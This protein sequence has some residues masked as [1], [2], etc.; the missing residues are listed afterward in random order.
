MQL[1]SRSNPSIFNDSR[2][3]RGYLPNVTQKRGFAG[4]LLQRFEILR[5]KIVHAQ[6]AKHLTTRSSPSVLGVCDC[7]SWFVTFVCQLHQQRNA[8]CLTSS[9]SIRVLRAVASGASLQR[10]LRVAQ[11]NVS[12]RG[13]MCNR[14]SCTSWLAW[15]MRL[16]CPA[17][18]RS[19]QSWELADGCGSPRGTISLGGLLG[20]TST[21]EDSATSVSSSSSC[22]TRW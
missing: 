7:S 2:G 11:S 18:Q 10:S 16:W 9:K 5:L 17:H 6:V 4:Q 1:V 14:V 3:L 20:V 13:S 12:T 15:G 19:G 22:S 21:G 8:A